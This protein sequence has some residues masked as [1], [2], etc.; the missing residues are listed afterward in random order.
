MQELLHAHIISKIGAL[1]NSAGSENGGFASIL[2]TSLG[3][4]N[5]S[6]LYG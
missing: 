1:V 4:V 6:F 3:I 5:A 2:S